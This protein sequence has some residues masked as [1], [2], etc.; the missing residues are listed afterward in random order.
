MYKNNGGD[1][2]WEFQWVEDSVNY[3]GQVFIAGLA[4]LSCVFGNL[5]AAVAAALN[6]KTRK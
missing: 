5:F 6:E 2:E 1:D 4:G 3:T